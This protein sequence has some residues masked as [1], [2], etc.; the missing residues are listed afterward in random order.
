MRR[1]IKRIF[2]LVLFAAALCG[3]AQAQS[4]DNLVFE[5]AGIR[6]IA[7][8]GGLLE[9][10]ERGMLKGVDRVGGTSSGAITACLVS[11][12]YS[13]QEIYEVIGDTDFGEFN[14]GRGIFIGGFHR[15]KKRWDTTKEKNLNVGWNHC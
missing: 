13:P 12:G 6:G 11:I 9:L 10:E 5:G 14:D 2:L 1:Q 4:I 15:L 3:K 7:Y 8:C